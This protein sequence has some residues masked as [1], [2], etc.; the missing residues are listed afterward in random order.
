MLLFD[1]IEKAHPDVYNILLQVMD[2]GQLTDNNGKMLNFRN[3]IIIMTTNAGASDFSRNTIG[4]GDHENISDNSD[5]IAR[6]FTPEFR[7]RLDSIIHFAP[8]SS[9]VVEMVVDKFID[10]MQA[11]LADR[12]VKIEVSKKARKYLSIKGYDHK[13]GARPLERIISDEIKKQLADEILFGKLCKGGKVTIDVKQE[14][15]T[16][17][18]TEKE[19]IGTRV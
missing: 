5:A 7:N 6:V 13:N 4:F 14:E 12:G 8:L 17:M 3:S 15:L 2:Y 16:F 18:F 1:E 19:V 10:S 11:Q 9:D